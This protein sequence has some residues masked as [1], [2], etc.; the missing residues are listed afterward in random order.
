MTRMTITTMVTMFPL[1]ICYAD[2]PVRSYPDRIPGSQRRRERS[3]SATITRMITTR[4]YTRLPDLT[5][6]PP[7][8]F[9]HMPHKADI[10]PLRPRRNGKGYEEAAP[11]NGPI[12]NA[13]YRS[14]L[15]PLLQ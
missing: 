1:L 9:A 15:P 2:L 12:I 4:M 5:T 7:S 13:D 14:E 6:L 11:R 8:A 3:S 10:Y